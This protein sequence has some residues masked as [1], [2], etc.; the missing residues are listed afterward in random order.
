MMTS[1]KSYRSEIPVVVEAMYFDG[2][3]AGVANVGSWL[4]SVLSEEASIFP[5]PMMQQIY[6][7]DDGFR[8]IIDSGSYVYLRDGVFNTIEKG[9]FDLLMRVEDVV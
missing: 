9:A 7:E 3:S 4:A 2:T 8:L 1:P 5:G 6:V